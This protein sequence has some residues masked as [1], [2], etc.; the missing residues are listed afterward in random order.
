MVET[1]GLRLRP[2]VKE[3]VERLWEICRRQTAEEFCLWGA[4]LVYEY[5]PRL[6]QMRRRFEALSGDGGQ[7]GGC[8]E[9]GELDPARRSGVLARVLLEKGQRG[10][11]RGK[12]LVNLVLDQAME[13]L[14]LEEVRL[15][16]Y[17]GNLRAQRCYETCGFVR[18]EALLRPGRE[19][20]WWMRADLR[21]RGG[22]PHPSRNDG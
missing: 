18:G 6:E 22:Q 15:I 14:G 16:V 11:G 19:D 9:I 17:G 5:P 20:A 3:D 21:G 1:D 8:A 12:E 10:K 13:A 7:T 4:D 2:A